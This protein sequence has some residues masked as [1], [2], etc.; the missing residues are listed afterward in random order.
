MSTTR[1]DAVLCAPAKDRAGVARHCLANA[2]RARR[3]QGRLAARIL[4]LDPP[5]AAVA[6][7]VELPDEDPHTALGRLGA[8]DAE[9]VRRWTRGDLGPVQIAAALALTPNAVSIR[10]RRARGRLRA[11]LRKLGPGAGHDV[12]EEG[13]RP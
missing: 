5:A 10:L 12:P 13:R 1:R 9:I 4:A 3:R 6:E 7:P 8:L 11:E 2:E